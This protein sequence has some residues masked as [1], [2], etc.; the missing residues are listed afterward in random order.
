MRHCRLST[1]LSSSGS[2]R[3]TP[4]VACL[5]LEFGRSRSPILCCTFLR[6]ASRSPSSSPFGQR[7]PHR[8]LGRVILQSR[9]PCAESP[10]PSEQFRAALSSGFTTRCLARPFAS[11][12]LKP[13]RPA[14]QF[15]YQRRFAGVSDYSLTGVS[16]ASPVS[17]ARKASLFFQSPSATR[18][19]ANCG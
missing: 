18:N 1:F 9:K 3:R 8:K 4:L 12:P 14:L 19:R 13:N 2:S 11:A 10:R 5:R 6:S 7:L 17:L 15:S 16:P